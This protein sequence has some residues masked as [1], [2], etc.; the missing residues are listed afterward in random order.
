M[1]T[2]AK[3]ETVA[4]GSATLMRT[5]IEVAFRDIEDLLNAINCVTG[6]RA[7]KVVRHGP[8]STP[9]AN[10][11]PL[12][13]QHLISEVGDHGLQQLCNLLREMSCLGVDDASEQNSILQSLKL[14]IV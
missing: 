6:A 4:A 11:L 5:G 2:S 1:P 14:E 8:H 10:D 12:P 9:S 7:S 13:L 3:C